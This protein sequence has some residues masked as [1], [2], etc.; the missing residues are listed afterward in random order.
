MN[1]MKF[2]A[3]H[4]CYRE[5]QLAGNHFEVDITMDYDMEK[6]S[7]SD[8]LC[9]ALDYAE[10]YEIVKQEMDVRSHLLEHLSR[11]ILDR[12]FECFPQLNEAT[13]SVAKLHPP[14]GGKM[15]SVSVIQRQTRHA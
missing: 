5:E 12:L 6:S 10:V 3:C 4:G 13:V 15:Q 11:R 7:R 2:F 8:D 14:M 9:D 1:G